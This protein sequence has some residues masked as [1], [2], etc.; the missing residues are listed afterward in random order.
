MIKDCYDSQTGQAKDFGKVK[1]DAEMSAAVQSATAALGLRFAKSACKDK[2]SAC[3]SLYA[4]PGDPPCSFDDKGTL[5]NGGQCGMQALLTLVN[6]VDDTKIT[7]SCKKDLKSWVEQ[8]CTPGGDV[9]KA[10]QGGVSS[11]GGASSSPSSQDACDYDDDGKCDPEETER[12]EN[13]TRAADAA[14]LKNS[15]PYQCRQFPK[16]GKGS[17]YEKLIE[18]AKI[19]CLNPE[20]NQFDPTGSAAIIEIMDDL[21]ARMTSMLRRMC[22]IAAGSAGEGFW[23]DDWTPDSASSPKKVMTVLPDYIRLIFDSDETFAGTVSQ[24]LDVQFGTGNNLKKMAGKAVA[25]PEPKLPLDDVKSNLAAKGW[26]AC[27]VATIKERCE[28][29]NVMAGGGSLATYNPASRQCELSADYYKA[30]CEK[31]LGVPG[32]PSTAVWDNNSGE[33]RI[34]PR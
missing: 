24:N 16:Y 1:D 5:L 10:T 20:T 17:V 26:G 11:S 4:K 34:M 13:E 32:A 8:L 9:S 18:R 19:V 29:V 31:L 12:Y 25:M 15:F 28:G 21:G 14:Q 6:T 22:D 7:M 3:A 23:V 30:V 27:E 2:V 33:C